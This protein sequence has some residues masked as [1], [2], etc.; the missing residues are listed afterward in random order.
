[1]REETPFGSGV[2]DV[3]AVVP[4]SAAVRFDHLHSW[5]VL[6]VILEGTTK[7]WSGTGVPMPKIDAI[8]TVRQSQR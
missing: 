4:S 2:N 7:S 3:M 5:H 8:A 6:E 1:M